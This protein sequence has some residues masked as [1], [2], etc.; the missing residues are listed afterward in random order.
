MVK[1]SISILAVLTAKYDPVAIQ[2]WFNCKFAREIIIVSTILFPPDFYQ[3][4]NKRSYKNSYKKSHK[5]SYKN[6]YKKIEVLNAEPIVFSQ[7]YNFASS[8]AKYNKLLFIS[9][10]TILPRDIPKFKLKQKTLMNDNV[11][12]M[13]KKLFNAM[14]GFNEYLDTKG[15]TYELYERLV[16]AGQVIK[17]LPFNIN[18][19]LYI[20]TVRDRIITNKWPWTIHSPRQIYIENLDESTKTLKKYDQ[21]DTKLSLDKILSINIATGLN[22]IKNQIFSKVDFVNHTFDCC[23]GQQFDVFIVSVIGQHPLSQITHIMGAWNEFTLANL[24]HG[25][26]APPQNGS[27]AILF[28]KFIIYTDIEYT[29][30][31]LFIIPDNVIILGDD[32]QYL[33]SD[34][35]AELYC[36]HYHY[37]YNYS[38]SISLS[39]SFKIRKQIDVESDLTVIILINSLI[40]VK[41]MKQNLLERLS[42][43]KYKFAKKIYLI[44]NNKQI[45]IQAMKIY[46]TRI[47]Y[48]YISPNYDTLD[49]LTYLFSVKNVADMIRL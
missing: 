28:E 17:P 11:M 38:A 25:K 24:T 31:E 43:E 19:E 13:P 35:N 14:N 12:L 37:R 45:I 4:Q 22:L 29:L 6:S 21:G 5:N 1:K 15:Y 44:S 33:L 47:L 8:F 41:D 9:D 40:T 2:S 48:K 26:I 3:I 42:E 30:R 10:S 36:G 49:D 46:P 34:S 16:R 20:Q 23:N 18:S 27:A 7:L 32:P 39:N